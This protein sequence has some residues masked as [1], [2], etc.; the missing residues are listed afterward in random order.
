MPL[1][2]DLAQK[3][4]A[5]H[6]EE[7]CGDT[8]EVLRRPDEIMVALSDGLGSGVKAG[9]L[10]TMTVKLAST[11]ISR[12]LPLDDVMATINQTLPVCKVR[13]L[14]YATLT[15]L[16]T[17]SKGFTRLLVNDSPQALLLR[18]GELL[19]VP[20]TQSI[21]GQKKIQHSQFQFQVGDTLFLFSDGVTHAGVGGV[22]EL[23]W[24]IRGLSYYLEK[25]AHSLSEPEQW[26]DAILDIVNILYQGQ[27]GDDAT[28]V[29]LKARHP[30]SLM[31][32]SGPPED[33][34]LDGELCKRLRDF[35]G[36]KVIA[37]GATGNMV[38]RQWQE[39][40]K[41]EIN[42]E[43]PTVPPKA[44]LPGAHL[45]TEGILTLNKVI[46]RLRMVLSGENI[47]PKDDGA[48]SLAREFLSSEEIHFLIGTALNP[49][50]R[51]LLSAV[52][53]PT[54]Q[55][56]IAELTRLLT[57]LGKQTTVEWF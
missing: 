56:A 10:S 22:L 48:S 27:P 25:K 16:T 11:L 33:P 7:L 8:V 13:G 17:D 29:V 49:A 42:Y 45:V 12:G 32:L 47:P 31:I 51:S 41:T 26:T 19:E 52:N 2:F 46:D 37:G 5:K 40:L 53:Y 4:L 18:Q 3:S 15:V 50:Y 39:M 38:A 6:G 34:K 36:R 20:F 43:D 1:A 14:A 9:I 54:R 35:P 24:G 55:Q 21:V 30:R 28:V 23:G 57:R 44:I